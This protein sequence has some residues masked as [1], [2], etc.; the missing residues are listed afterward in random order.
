MY[1]IQNFSPKVQIVKAITMPGGISETALEETV[2]IAVLAD[3]NEQLE[4]LAQTMQENLSA[5]Q[6]LQG[7][8]T[9]L[10]LID[11][12]ESTDINGTTYIEI[13]EEEYAE[14]QSL[15]PDLTLKE[16]NGVYYVS[17]SGLETVIMAKQEELASLNS[18]G[19]LV[20]LQIQSLVD[21][22]KQAVTLLSNLLAS[23]NETLMNIIGNIK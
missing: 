17:Q 8:V 4:S 5:R 14:L 15:Y 18:T 9:E 23:R 13:S 2:G 22:R 10:Q 7:E 6:E 19:E 21:Q 11:A 16:E 3:L 1:S 20:S 12:H